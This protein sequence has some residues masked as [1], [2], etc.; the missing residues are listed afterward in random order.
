MSF[1]FVADC[2]YSTC[3]KQASVIW[4]FL[5]QTQVENVCKGLKNLTWV[6]K[7]SRL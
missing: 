6:A 5:T 7:D 2:F 1:Y 4:P 3:R